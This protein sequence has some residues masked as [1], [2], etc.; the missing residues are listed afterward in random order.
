MVIGVDIDCVLNNLVASILGQYNIMSGD[1]LTE[2]DITDYKVSNFVKPEYKEQFNRLWAD[3]IV[4]HYVEWNVDWVMKLIEQ[5]KHDIYF[6]TATQP[7]NIY[8]KFKLLCDALTKCSVSMTEN[9]IINY[10]TGHLITTINKQ[11]IKVDIV[12][13]DCFDNFQLHDNNVWNICVSKPWNKKLVNRFNA[14]YLEHNPI[15]VCDDTNDIPDIIDTIHRYRE[16]E[17]MKCIT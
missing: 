14:I 9:E 8:N 15:L 6:V 11:L 10:I 17:G 1:N 7:S 16:K 4:W 3:P 12:V 13:D 5:H 2:D